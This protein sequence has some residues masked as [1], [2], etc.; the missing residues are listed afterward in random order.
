MFCKLNL[1][2]GRLREVNHRKSNAMLFNTSR[3]YDFTPSL[4]MNN[5]LFEVVEEIKL[6][7]VKISD[8]LKCNS[9]TK[10]I[11]TKACGRLWMLR[12]LKTLGAS[13]AELEDSYVKQTRS[14]L[15]YSAV[16]WHAGLTQ[17]NI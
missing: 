9:N 13:H 16:V 1:R 15:E 4:S 7:G 10:Y 17:I 8:D 6:L 2:Q 11:T 12:R 3:K 5:E 14:V